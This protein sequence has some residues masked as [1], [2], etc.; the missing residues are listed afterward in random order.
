[1]NTTSIG[2]P[3]VIKCVGVRGKFFF[4]D[5]SWA[6]CRQAGGVEG[7]DSRVNKAIESSKRKIVGV[8]DSKRAT[9]RKEH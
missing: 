5:P 7:A 4:L 1:M 2:A 8:R 9:I 3:A 6:R